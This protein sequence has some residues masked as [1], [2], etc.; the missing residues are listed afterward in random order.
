MYE[1]ICVDLNEV[2]AHFPTAIFL[3]K[4]RQAMLS[5]ACSSF[6]FVCLYLSLWQESKRISLSVSNLTISSD[7]NWISSQSDWS[8]NS[9]IFSSFSSADSEHVNLHTVRIINKYQWDFGARERER[10]F[11]IIVHISFYVNVRKDF[12]S[13]Q[14]IANHVTCN[15]CT[16]LRTR[17]YP[18]CCDK[19]F[20]VLRL[21]GK[22][23]GAAYD[24]PIWVRLNGNKNK[25]TYTYTWMT[26]GPY[27]R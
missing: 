20:Y 22:E 12:R 5:L 16:S 21:R 23:V 13:K 6:S 18:T 14:T 4:C 1:T 3:S 10:A 27:F 26:L 9:Y 17:R 11:C 25:Q 19:V 7:D 24:G 15:T 2:H 8:Y